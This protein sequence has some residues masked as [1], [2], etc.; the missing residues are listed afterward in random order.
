LAA[1]SSTRASP[2]RIRCSPCSLA[3]HFLT[4]TSCRSLGDAIWPTAWPKEGDDITTNGT[5]FFSLDDSTGGPPMQIGNNW[6]RLVIARHLMNINVGFL[7]G[8]ASTTPLPDLWQ[9]QWHSRW[10]LKKNLP[11]GS[12]WTR[13]GPGSNRCTAADP[14]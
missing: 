7:D 10:D 14:L 4:H 5:G 2:S 11:S 1:A 3:T 8:H 12:R 9:L 13:S 6:V